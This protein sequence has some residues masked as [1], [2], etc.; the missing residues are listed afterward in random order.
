MRRLIAFI[1]LAVAMLIVAIVGIPTLRNNI[2]AGTEFE[3][4]YDIL[5]KVTNSDGVSY[6]GNA[7]KTVMNKAT[8]NINDRLNM[9]D[10]SYP[11]VSV[12]NDEY[13]RVTVPAKNETELT[14]I[15]YTLM[16]NAK[17]TIR[18]NQNNLLANGEDVLDSVTLAYSNDTPYIGVKIKDYDKF[19]EITSLQ[20]QKYTG[21]ENDTSSVIAFWLGFE[22]SFPEALA[23]EL[24]YDGDSLDNTSYPYTQWKLLAA[25]VV[26]SAIE[27]DF[28][29]RGS[30]SQSNLKVLN[31][32]LA[33]D[34]VNFVLNEEYH[35]EHGSLMNSNIPSMAVLAAVIGLA[36]IGI[37]MIISYRFAGVV[38]LL[39][40][41]LNTIVII[42]AYNLIGGLFGTDT[43]VAIVIGV[44]LA[45]NANV[46]L[47][48]RIKDEIRKGKTLARSYNEGSRKS[49]S[50]IID[51]TVLVTIAS[52]VIFLIGNQIVKSFAAVM[53]ISQ[54]SI[55]VIVVLL[56]RLL[57]SL[58]CHS[59][60]F[61]GKTGWFGVKK[62][63]IEDLNN[64]AEHTRKSIFDKVN[65]II[66]WKKVFSVSAAILLVGLVVGLVCQ[67]ASGS[68]FNYDSQISNGTKVYYRTV[69]PK[70]STKDGVIE[71]FSDDAYAGK[72]PNS[73]TI[74]TSTISFTD[75]QLVDYKD[76][77]AN[78]GL[79]TDSVSRN[80]VTVY[81][82]TVIFNSELNANA[83]EAIN[84][85]F[86]AEEKAFY[87]EDNEIELYKTNYS[88]AS[89]QAYSAGKTAIV[90]TIAFVVL[91]A[92]S[93]IYL[94]I[95]F[96]WSYAIAGV[97]TLL[98]NGLI[99]L[100]ILAITRVSFSISTIAIVLAGTLLSINNLVIVFDQLR[101]NISEAK[102]SWTPETR[103]EFFNRAL[104]E[105]MYGQLFT[106]IAVFATIICLFIFCGVSILP[107]ALTLLFSLLASAFGCYFLLSHFWVYF[108]TR[109][110]VRKANRKAN[111]K[112]RVKEKDEVEEYIFFGVND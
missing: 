66:N 1:S 50:T 52:L 87:D 78:Y 36:I 84:N 74:G 56:T 94:A 29:A 46:V 63:E 2:N 69:D 51:T 81:N 32:I 68:F 76:T 79:D 19:K 65:F 64:L 10:I 105:T 37:L 11:Q 77:F 13:L 102:V 33:T 97:I 30:F 111:R 98:H 57:L 55:I 18:D 107:L 91:L 72:K 70:F 21:Q 45:V 58:I 35:S 25:I 7:L 110:A 62:D 9:L 41:L 42:V 106:A 39:S 108:D 44:G 49:V 104:Q 61:V 5:Y 85:Y 59:S 3:G 109:I 53:I 75:S 99:L 47:V 24:G 54:V 80:R 67:F 43:L 60:K 89:Y 112:P 40:I 103:R 4:G 34:P 71:F 95:R 82:V 96:S 6:Q 17:I 86:E 73:V 100:A 16:N 22:E 48:E 26:D 8:S 15:R 92:A 14:Q 88:L 93:A 12:E 23:D 31:S 38:S 90:A 101:E 28:T 20:A 83:K 27:E